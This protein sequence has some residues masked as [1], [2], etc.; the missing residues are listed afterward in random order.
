MGILK[1]SRY[2]FWASSSIYVSTS[3]FL[4]RNNHQTVSNG[5][6]LGSPICFEIFMTSFLFLLLLSFCSVLLNIDSLDTGYEH[7]LWVAK[8]TP[9]D[10][11]PQRL[12]GLVTCLESNALLITRVQRSPA[13]GHG[14]VTPDTWCWHVLQRH[15]GP[16]LDTIDN[17]CVTT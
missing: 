17:R 12:P 14:H 10:C 8:V 16:Q 3:G 4:P 11:I 9:S 7:R 6:G 2:R 5:C 15:M 1:R 13:R